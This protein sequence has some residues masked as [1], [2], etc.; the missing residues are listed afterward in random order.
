MTQPI[1]QPWEPAAGSDAA[2]A[3]FAKEG[4]VVADDGTPIAYTVRNRGGSRVPV[5]FANGWSCS[6]AYWV[7]L[8]PA[9]EA[10]G[11]PCILPDT[12]GHG[13]SGLPR[14]AGRGARNLTIDDLSMARIARDLVAVLDDAGFDRALVVGHSM[15]VQTA[16]EVYRQIPERVAGLVLLAGTYENP[17]KTFYGYSIGDKL[18]PLLGATMRYLPEVV[19][20]VQATIGPASV[21]HFGARAAKA[22]GPKATAA[23]LHPYLLHLKAADLAVVMLMAG[24]MRAHSAADLLPEI[25]VPTLVVAAGADVFTPARCSEAMHHRIAGSELITF[26]EA[27]HT[28]PVEEPDAIA[29]A[30]D[31]FVARRLPAPKPARRARAAKA[32]AAAEAAATKRPAK[33]TPRTG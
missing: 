6:D 23:Q 17:A 2:Y 11:H 19:K 7:D 14:P 27:G 29:A 1:D 9:L 4:R 10:R 15:G 3:L 28:L 16:L 5:L 13:R 33:G 20:P 21:G 18:F 25:T 32:P 24:A 30:I 31:D 22:A 8:L 26:P 12:R